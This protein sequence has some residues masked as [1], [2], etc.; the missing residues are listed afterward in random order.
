MTEVLRLEN[1]R[2]FFGKF[3]AVDGVSFTLHEGGIYL[4]VGP[5]G[6]GKTTLVNCI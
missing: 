4:L 6:C 3:A 5:N 2:K 1:V